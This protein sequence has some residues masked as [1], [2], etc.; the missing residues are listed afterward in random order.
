MKSIFLFFFFYTLNFAAGQTFV[1]LQNHLEWQD[2]PSAEEKEE[3]WEMS[4]SYCKSLHLGNHNDWRPPTVE[5]LQTLVP[6]AQNKIKGKKL[7]YNSTSDY[8]TSEEYKED[9]A[10]AWEIHIGSGHHFYNDKCET[11][12]VRCVRTKF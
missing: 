11:A 1:D 3:K 4:K 5:E 8:W 10:N 9:D 6:I 12:N 7:Q 2:T